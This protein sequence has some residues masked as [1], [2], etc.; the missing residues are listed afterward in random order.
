MTKELKIPK[1]KEGIVIDHIP[2]GMAVR[3]LLKLIDP[4]I[5]ESGKYVV[6]VAINVPS[7]KYGKKDIIKIE[8]IEIPE[9]K[10]KYMRL[11]APYGTVNKIKDYEV[12]EKK[13]IGLPDEVEDILKCPN[14]NCITNDQREPVV[15]K[16]KVIKKEYPIRLRCWYCGKYVE[17]EKIVELLI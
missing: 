1:I 16:F 10:L 17:S 15:P 5:W 6:E 3:I 14:P 8:N 12:V 7:K 2:P 9:E 11:L 4:E 13:K